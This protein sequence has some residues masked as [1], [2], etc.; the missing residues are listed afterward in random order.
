MT[1]ELQSESVGKQ[2]PEG[3]IHKTNV[4]ELLTTQNPQEG[5]DMHVTLLSLP[6]VPEPQLSVIM[7]HVPLVNDGAGP[8]LVRSVVNS[9]AQ[10]LCETQHLGC[11]E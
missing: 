8:V 5:S 9:N 11:V 6:W 1:S 10:H 4:S 2:I 3:S 7:Q